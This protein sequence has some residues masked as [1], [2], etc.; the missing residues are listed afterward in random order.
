V[1][2]LI[3]FPESPV[4]VQGSVVG[5]GSAAVAWYSAIAPPSVASVYCIETKIEFFEKPIEPTS[6]V[7]VLKNSSVQPFAWR[8]VESCVRRFSIDEELPV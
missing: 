4:A 7:I 6:A 1:F 2:E 5:D 3:P 8:N